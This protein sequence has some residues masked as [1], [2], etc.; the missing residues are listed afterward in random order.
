[1]VIDQEYN[2]TSKIIHVQKGESLR[3][4]FE[5]LQN[6]FE[7]FGCPVMMGG[8]MDASSKGVFGV[9]ETEDGQ[10]YF[11]IVD[12]HYHGKDLSQEELALKGW[13]KWQS[14]DEFNES[15]FYNLCLPQVKREIK[16]KRP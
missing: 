16:L 13:V 5:K 8:D 1:M 7:D 3:N 2:I 4:L 6:H 12:P 11:L 10:K 14:V 9:A 15:S